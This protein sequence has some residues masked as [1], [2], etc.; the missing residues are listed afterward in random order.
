MRSSDKS[1]C[2]SATWW[3]EQEIQRGVVNVMAAA[4]LP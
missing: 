3:W 1:A 2:W 4:P